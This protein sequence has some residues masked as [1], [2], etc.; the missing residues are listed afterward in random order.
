MSSNRSIKLNMIWNVSGLLAEMVTGF[1]CMPLLIHRLGEAS[2]G[3]WVVIG[4]MTSY[5]GLLDLGVRGSIGRFV[6]LYSSK[7]DPV[8]VNK[9]LISGLTWLFVASTSICLIGFLMTSLF[10]R[11]FDV[12]Q[13]NYDLVVL[14]IRIVL[15]QIGVYLIGTA[16]DAMLWGLQRFDLINYVDIPAA[17]MRLGLTYALIAEENDLSKV[18]MIALGLSLFNLVLKS[19]LCYRS[20]PLLQIRFKYFER[21]S[22][23]EVLAFGSW[24]LVGSISKVTKRQFPPLLIGSMLG[25]AALAPFSVADRILTAFGFLLGAVTGVITPFAT[26]LHGKGQNGQQK[27]L[28]IKGG[29]YNSIISSCL[30]VFLLIFSE[31]LIKEWVGKTYEGVSTLLLILLA[32]EYLGATQYITSGILQATAK[33]RLSAVSAILEMAMVFGLAKYLI[34]THGIVGAILATAIPAFIFRGVITILQGCVV[35]NTSLITYLLRSFFPPLIVSSACGGVVYFVLHSFEQ[36]NRF[37][38]A[39]TGILYFALCSSIFWVMEK[40]NRQ[41]RETKDA[42]PVAEID[43]PQNSLA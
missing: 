6:A 11:V 18:A 34:P 41:T 40:R 9:T 17:F 36:P 25:L 38:S 33:H 20:Y 35:T 1:V 13:Q 37:L 16:F 24:N 8:G 23:K 22:L 2:Y 29:Y 4:S 12:P 28:F 5:F 7:D 30:V 26:N 14:T 32:G 15:V 3:V 31:I 10:F 43:N 39:V 27:N 19:W 21:E 42:Q